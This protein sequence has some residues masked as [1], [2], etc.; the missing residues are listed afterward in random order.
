MAQDFSQSPY[1]DDYDSLKG[2][3]KVLFKPG[4]AVQTRE[5]N[6]TQSILQNQIGNLSD[7]LFENGSAI[8]GGKISFDNE[9]NYIKLYDT[10]NSVDFLYSNFSNR[11]VYGLTTKIVAKVYNGFNVDS[12]NPATLYLNYLSSG[13]NDEKTFAAGEVLQLVTT[14][15]VSG[16]SGTF[17]VN[18][19]I[20][21]ALSGATAK[22]IFKNNNE[23]SIIYTGV[24]AFQENEILIGSTSIA[25]ATFIS[26]ETVN[27]YCQIQTTGDIDNP[28]G[29]GSTAYLANG[30]YYIDGYFVNSIAQNIIISEYS[31]IPTVKIGFNKEV[32]IITS[33]DDSS[34]LDNA[35]G[36]PNVNA[37]GA[38]RF[39][40]NLSLI[41]YGSEESTSD[42]FIEIMRVSKG[43]VISNKSTSTSY[44]TILDTLARRTY[45]ESGNYTVRPFLIDI[46]EFLNEDSNNGVYDET[47]FSYDTQDEALNASMDI[48]EI[49][50]PGS[51][52]LYNYKWYPY[53]THDL[54]LAACRARLAVGVEPGKAY[55][56]GYEIELTNKFY[57]PLLKARDTFL[58]N[59]TSTYIDIGN[60]TLISNVYGLPNINNYVTVS[61]RDTATSVR[62][63]LAGSEIG[64][65][66][67]KM[68]EY[69]SGTLG[70][71]SSQYKLYLF[72]ISM[73]TGYSFINN[74]KSLGINSTFTA[75]T[76]LTSSLAS[77][78]NIDKNSLIFSLPNSNIKSISDISYNL[79]QVFTGTTTSGGVIEINAPTGT[80]FVNYS[81]TNYSLI[82][83][84]NGNLVNLTGKVA[85][86]GSPTG[87]SITISG[88][89]A[90][91][92]YT[93]IATLYRNV[94]NVKSKVLQSNFNL[95][96]A[97]PTDAISLTK[98]DIYQIVGIYESSDIG[99]PATTSDT[100]IM[101]HYNLNNGQT[102]SYYGIGSITRKNT[103]AAPTGQL[104]VVFD[105][106]T[107]S[108]GDY[109]TADSYNGQIDYEDIQTFISGSNTYSL[110]DCL[111]LRPRVD[112]PTGT[113]FTSGSLPKIMQPLSNFLSDIEYYLPRTD[114]LYLDYKGN[115]KIKSGTSSLN[116]QLPNVDQNSMMLYALYLDAYTDTPNN[117]SKLYKENKRYTMRDIGTLE[118]RIESLEDYVLLSQLEQSTSGM[119]IID[120]DGVERYK[121]GFITDSFKNHSIGN[122]YDSGYKCAIDSTNGILRPSFKQYN[123]ALEKSDIATTIVEKNN[124]YFLPYTEQSYM[125]NLINTS[126]DVINSN[127]LISWTGRVS[128]T[129]SVN[130]NYDNASAS[131]NTDTTL[132][133]EDIINGL[134]NT[135]FGSFITNWLGTLD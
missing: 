123:I 81:S 42:N 114:I 33:D 26:G 113:T 38:D 60:Y 44:S 2:F 22:L 43:V 99:T 30:V 97:S 72:D 41:S 88:L 94:S 17:E 64:T 103:F 19:T 84:S 13:E 73:N 127:E 107:H 124:K 122:V 14:I 71:T 66:K 37:P 75:D 10:Y 111:D 8:K 49:D 46:R 82:Y 132:G 109:F 112:E 128:L 47:D 55:V 36:T 1:F 45:D 5:L 130:N 15:N 69:N 23:F 100:N 3:L 63:T 50:S 131:L 92:G 98:A 106:F 121:S 62:G 25:N 129:P 115:F 85:L 4:Y 20:T 9:S 126:Y 79:E 39:K 11:F 57:I 54:F 35:N 95:A 119:S 32:N 12:S 67:V 61:L 116:P 56:L 86:S 58:D 77:L 29:L 76:V 53:T 52:H 7:N 117:V 135:R 31:T 48:F 78:Y 108:S 89:T 83:T 74:V 134:K 27:K 102:E 70:A 51:A 28:V 110:R 101:S 133:Y 93:L 6:Q 18:E 68:I 87:S 40:M 96:V 120:T 90:S 24:G 104:L 125:S 118:S 80:K 59:N 91:A 21:G 34:L 16:I 105:Y 65:A